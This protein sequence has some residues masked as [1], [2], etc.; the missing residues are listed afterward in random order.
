MPYQLK[1]YPQVKGQLRAVPDRIKADV[2]QAILELP[3]DPYPPN[4]EELRD[5]YAGIY[6]IKVDGWRIFYTVDEG[7]RVVTVRAIK[8]RDKYTY[9]S[10]P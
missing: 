3:S 6:K 1:W 7:D 4:A 5:Q 8:R 10:I 2:V 9:R